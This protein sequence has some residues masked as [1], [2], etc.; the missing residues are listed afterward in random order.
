MTPDEFC[1]GAGITLEDAARLQIEF[2]SAEQTAALGVHF[3][4]RPAA[5]INYFNLRGERTN[6]Y[7]VR[8]LEE[9]RND[10]G[11]LQRYTQPSGSLTEVYLPPFNAWLPCATAQRPE[12]IWITEGEKKAACATKRGLNCIGLGGVN[13]YQSARYGIEMLDP[14]PMFNWVGRSV[15]I[16]FDSDINEKPQVMA[17]MIHLSSLLTN[18]GAFVTVVKLPPPPVGSQMSKWGL[19]DYLLHPGNSVDSLKDLLADCLP[20]DEGQKLWGMNADF[21][22]IMQPPAVLGLEEGQL[23]DP[24][25]FIAFHAAN[26]FYYQEKPAKD[27]VIRVKTALAP[28]WMKWEER[29][30]FNKLIYEPGQP[31]TINRDFNIW[32]GWAIE[33]VEPTLEQIQPWH[34]LME[35]VFHSAPRVKDWFEQWCAYPMQH[36]GEKMF[37]YVLF[38]SPIYGIGKT[39]VPYLLMDIYGTESKYGHGNATEIK[40]TDLSGKKDF[41]EWMVKK[42]FVYGDEISSKDTRIGAGYIRGLVTQERVSINE[43]FIKRYTIRD[44]INYMFSSNY[45]DAIFIDA[46]DRRALI[47]EIWGPRRSNAF[48]QMMADWRRNGG[49]KYLFWYLLHKDLTGFQPKF[50]PPDHNAKSNMARLSMTEVGLWLDGIRESPTEVL[51]QNGVNPDKAANCDLWSVEQLLRIY[52][53]L[54]S[55]TVGAIGM[56]RQLALIGVR[57]VNE[58]KYMI[59]SDG[60]QCPVAIRNQA[61]WAT[62][63]QGEIRSHWEKWNGK[64]DDT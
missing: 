23:M 49:A 50:S 53:P 60:R 48:Y 31:Q 19:D 32:P 44:C 25:K 58:G 4:R 63:M 42:Q 5:K 21:A 40:S 22:A 43:K 7:R 52:D 59:M 62:A 27:G 41:N 20:S 56:G 55:K 3:Y 24:G 64:H 45:P 2:L 47:H 46:N 57:H 38:W 54:A 15:V 16:C 61:K 11:E 18:K 34:D 14:L 51:I 29:K 35:F 28:R 26:Q 6:F 17:A 10:K 8:Y 9:V 36:P 33:P 13:S 1:Q 37:S 12:Q 39:M 30:Q